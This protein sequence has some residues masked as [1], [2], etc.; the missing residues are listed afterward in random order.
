M[1]GEVEQGAL[2]VRGLFVLLAVVAGGGFKV[3]VMV[4]MLAQ[5]GALVGAKG[6]SGCCGVADG[7]MGWNVDV[8]IPRLL[9]IHP[10]C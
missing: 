2:F 4:Q 8:A 6:D 7:E 10:Q 5:L 9:G 1:Q 3:G